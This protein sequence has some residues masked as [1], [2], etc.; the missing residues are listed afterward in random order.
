[1]MQLFLAPILALILGLIQETAPVDLS[2]QERNTHSLVSELRSL[3]DL[4]RLPVYLDHTFSGQVSSYDTTGGNDDGFSGKYSFLKRNEDSSLVILD[5]HGAG[6]INRM[7]TPTPSSDTLDF[8]MDGASRPSWSIRYID[9]F[10]GL[11][12]PFVA[13]LCGNQLGG[14]FCYLP[15][16]FSKGCK[17]VFRGKKTQFHQIQYRMYAAGDQVKSFNPN[18]EENEKAELK[19]IETLWAKKTKSVIDFY[20]GTIL[21]ATDQPILHAG[22]MTTLL[23]LHE[24]GRILGIELDPGTAFEGLYKNID[25]KITWDDE[26]LP[27]V[28]CPVAD[29]FGYAF[30]KAAMQSLFIG[31]QENKNYCYLPMPFD[32]AAKIELIYRPTTRHPDQTVSINSKIYYSLQKRNPANEGRLYVQWNKKLLSTPGHP[33][34]LAEVKG[35][36]HYIGTILQAQGLL[37]GMTYFFE[38][39]DETTID[40]QP[41]LHGTGSEDYFNGG[42]YA[43]LDR[44]DGA[45]S[46]PLHGALDYSLPFCRTGGYRWCLGDKLTFEHDFYHTIEHGPV[47][48]AFPVD[49]TSLAFYYNDTPPISVLTPG[50]ELSKVFIPDTLVIYPQLMDYN[51]FGNMDIKTSWKYGTGGESYL[52]T[53]GKDTWLRISLKDLPASAYTLYFEIGKLSEGCDFSVWQRQRMISDWVSTFSQA[54]TRVPALKINDL[55]LDEN[56]NTLTIRFRTDATHNKLLFHRMTLV[57]KN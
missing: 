54:E 53:P 1:M 7:W 35:K 11:Q 37:A 26:K 24:G 15:I 56:Q 36:G 30:G 22:Q 44:W 40:G 6:V 4:S 48:N 32:H 45:M 42:W 46:L 50:N 34:V 41:R 17:I 19:K 12:Y 10:S 55:Q 38:G 28:Y 9:L 18:L 27:A 14:Y 29:F 3:N 33:H 13:P 43:M 57:K 25:I 20:S 21:H 52:F 39:D 31:N 16:P 23:D 51:V 47:G 2:Y 5:L 49:Y 8:Y